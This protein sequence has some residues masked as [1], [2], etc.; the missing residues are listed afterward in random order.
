MRLARSTPFPGTEVAERWVAVT[1]TGMTSMSA[2]LQGMTG[3]VVSIK[4]AW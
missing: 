4:S 1:S 3:R 2:R